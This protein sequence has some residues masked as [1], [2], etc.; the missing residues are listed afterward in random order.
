M[1]P[2]WAAGMTWGSA[3][4]NA[5]KIVSMVVGSAMLQR[6]MAAPAL[7]LTMVPSGM[8][9]SSARKQPSCTSSSGE[10]IALKATRAAAM[11]PDLPELSGEWV[12]GFISEKSTVMVEPLMVTVVLILIG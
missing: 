1:S 4:A 5:F 6:P 2:L 7:A 9:T 10:V 3:G 8:I 12:C 11:P